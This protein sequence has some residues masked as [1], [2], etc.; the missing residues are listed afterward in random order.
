MRARPEGCSVCAGSALI[1]RRRSWHYTSLVTAGPS[2]VG[3]TYRSLAYA[4][5]RTPHDRS[6]R[7]RTLSPAI[8]PQHPSNLCFVE[9]RPVVQPTA[10]DE[11][12]ARLHDGQHTDGALK[13]FLNKPF[14]PVFGFI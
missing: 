7:R 4:A 14:Q 1:R 8:S 9:L 2:V 6:F 11:L 12:P 13:S 3:R 10:A 5:R